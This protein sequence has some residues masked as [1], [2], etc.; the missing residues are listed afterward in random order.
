MLIFWL[1]S[2]YSTKREREVMGC[3][4]LPKVR[5]FALPVKKCE[6]TLKERLDL[7]VKLS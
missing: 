2:K 4:H 6:L 3:S 5:V 1:K 7:L